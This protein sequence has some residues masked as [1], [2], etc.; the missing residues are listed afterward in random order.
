MNEKFL[1]NSKKYERSNIIPAAKSRFESSKRREKRKKLKRLI[2]EARKN[3]TQKSSSWVKKTEKNE[4]FFRSK[5]L[6]KKWKFRKSPLFQVY[7]F[8]EC[9]GVT[10]EM[11][12]LVNLEKNDWRNFRQQISAVFEKISSLP[13]KENI[14]KILRG[15][16]GRAPKK[17]L[18]ISVM[19]R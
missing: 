17:I 16:G 18:T 5:F 11:Q 8:Q 12:A 4:T 7:A 6:V 9:M 15:F 1:R 2:F 3:A 19:P 13:D 14:L 10:R